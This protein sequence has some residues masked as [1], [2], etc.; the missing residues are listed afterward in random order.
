MDNMDDSLKKNTD[1]TL[2]KRN[3]K[4]VGW[5][6]NKYNLTLFLVIAFAILIRIYYFVLTKSQPLWW[7]EAEY[8][9]LAQKWIHGNSYVLDPVRQV[10]FPLIMSIF[11]RISSS[12]LLSRALIFLFSTSSVIGVYLLGKEMYDK[13]IGMLASFLM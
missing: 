12:E 3:E 13:K 1:E 7:D 2:K 8:M 6:K 4:I 11:L 10:L 9:V 5:F